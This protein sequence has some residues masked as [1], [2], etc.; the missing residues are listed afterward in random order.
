MYISLYYLTQIF[1]WFSSDFQIFIVMSLPFLI[2]D[3]HV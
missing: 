2:H 1:S 3:F